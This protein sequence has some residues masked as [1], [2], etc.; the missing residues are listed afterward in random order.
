MKLPL[1]LF[2][3]CRYL[4]PKRTFVSFIT[5]ISILGPALGVA[6]LIIVNSIM[7]GFQTNI[8]KGIMSWQSH[9]NVMPTWSATFEEQEVKRIMKAMQK[10]DI[11]AAPVITDNALIQVKRGHEQFCV[12]KVVYGINPKHERSIT[13]LLNDKFQGTFDIREKQ[14]II[15]WRMAQSLGL[16][17]GS[18]FLLHSPKRL[19]QNIQFDD[20]GKL[21]VGN[22]DEIYLPEKVTVVG[23]FDMGIAD[24]DDSIIYLH[25]DQ[26]A[27]LHG[28][29]W[30]SATA[31]QGK[32]KDPMD[33]TGIV[34][35]LNAELTPTHG[36]VTTRIVTWQERNAKL[37][38]TLR[39]EH[40]L[41][42]FLMTFILIVASFSIA[43]TLITVV[44]KKTREIGI[45][46]AMGVSS[47]TVARI[48]IVEGLVIG[49]IGSAL[50][51]LIGVLVVIY[52]TPVAACISWIVGHDVFP[53]ELYHLSELPA[54][55]KMTD[56]TT[57]NLLAILICIFS[58][59]IPSLFSALMKPAK[60]LQDA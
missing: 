39:V 55:L 5:L 17:I 12:P 46:K 50:G 31:I 38:E 60:S 27:D 3:A 30:R 15:G 35:K 29:E 33:M 14:A 19:T 48:F 36:L 56:L 59:L 4:K 18:D 26:V 47:F 41:L 44:V 24:L 58:A 2:L 34:S 10:L 6:I 11:V 8:K 13:G 32:V 20:D 49:I 43:A 40:L 22:V 52:R 37:F 1:D 53:A 45:M 51:T 54:Q 28:L 25:I 42:L 7:Q 9:L 21:D 57:F 23:I 16:K